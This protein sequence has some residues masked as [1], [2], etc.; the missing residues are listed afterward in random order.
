MMA[1][2][3]DF[4]RRNKEVGVFTRASGWQNP[5]EELAVRRLAP[6]VRGKRILDVGVGGGRTISLLTLLSDVYVG[7]DF[8]APMIASAKRRYP[9]V[10]LQVADARDLAQFESGSFDFVFFSYNGIDTMDE[11]DRQ[12]V[13]SA[14][15]R[16]LSESG[17]FA[18]STL[19]R[20]GRSFHETPFQLRR[21]GTAWQF[22]ALTAAHLVWRNAG[23]PKRMFRRIHHWRESRRKYVNHDGWSTSSLAS[24]DFMLMNH[25]VTLARLR[26]EL[27]ETGF[28]VITVI[29][30]DAISG[31]LPD[32]A[33]TSSDDSFHAITRR[34]T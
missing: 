17:V 8:S 11:A 21:P 32:D 30:S 2:G 22:G 12:R 34:R 14:V 6:L 26:T 15:H 4:Y 20:D 13:F 9:E 5:G 7:V 3:Q 16:V 24:T 28:D 25:F 33:M 10:D 23:D 27:D 19:N 31:P 1:E 18:F 29:G